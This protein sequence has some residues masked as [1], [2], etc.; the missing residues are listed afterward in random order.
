[1][2]KIAK[3]IEIPMA[4][5]LTCGEA[6]QIKEKYESGETSTK[7]DAILIA[8]KYGFALAMRM[9]ANRRK[10]GAAHE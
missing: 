5:D 9:E 3:E 7:L 10:R 4:Y 2:W 6:I 8:F 1:M